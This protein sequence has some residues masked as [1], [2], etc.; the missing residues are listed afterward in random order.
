MRDKYTKDQLSTKDR[1]IFTKMA[2]KNYNTTKN[3]EKF[4]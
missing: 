2:K 1:T 3:I 4:Y